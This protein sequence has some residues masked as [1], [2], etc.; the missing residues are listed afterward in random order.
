SDQHRG[1]FQ[2][3]LL[4]GVAMDGV[5]PYRQVLTHGFTVDAQGKKMSKSIGNVVEPQKVIDQMGADVLRLW[6]AS[7]DYRNEMSVSD[8]ILRRSGDAYR[9]IR[10]TARFLLANLNGFEPARDLRPLD[11]MVALDRWIVDRAFELQQR[12]DDAYAR[13]DFAEIVQALSNFC[14][15]DLGSVY[16]DVTKDRLYTMPEDSRGRRSAQSAMYRIAEAFVRWIAPVLTFTA[17]EMWRHLPAPAEGARAGNVL[18]ATWYDGL[19][20]MPDDATLSAADFER[21]LG[22]REQVSRTL[23]PMRA[24]G[25]IGAALEAEIVL[26]APEADR[27][28]I[29][30][31]VDELRFLFISGDVSV[32]PSGDAQIEVVATR[33]GKSKCV[34]CW[35]YQASVG[36]A[37]AHPGLCARCV[38][39]VEGDGEDRRW[40]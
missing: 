33:T 18:F 13:Y 38:D 19:A 30:A 6:I 39:N 3:S 26:R 32:E 17:D 35:H 23:E 22:L 14:S 28:W 2:S 36:I 12:I 10:N 27:A 8:E 5:A 20:A 37:P 21:L 34:R 7:A 25:E 1:W 9:R 29:A 31:F 4:T 15:V 16:L 11:D 24:A 40:F